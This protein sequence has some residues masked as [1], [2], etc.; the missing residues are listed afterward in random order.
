[1]QQSALILP[2]RDGSGR[3]GPA[4]LIPPGRILPAAGALPASLGVVVVR[5]DARQQSPSL[6]RA[7]PAGAGGKE[8]SVTTFP[9]G[10]RFFPLGWDP[11]LGGLRGLPRP[12]TLPGVLSPESRLGISGGERGLPIG[13][14]RPEPGRPRGARVT[15]WRW[16][17]GR[18]ICT[19]NPW[20]AAQG[21]A[22]RSRWIG[23]ER[24][25]LSAEGGTRG[26]D[27][28]ARGTGTGGHG[29]PP[30]LPGEGMRCRRPIPGCC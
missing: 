1:M 5:T 2:G 9:L 21:A 11:E 22:E 30:A 19:I 15:R 16:Q 10:D 28:L 27:S 18:Q 29:G 12:G 17:R 24:I 8:K 6:R 20:A 4:A 26:G 25:K 23:R 7:S 14:L 3:Q 13:V